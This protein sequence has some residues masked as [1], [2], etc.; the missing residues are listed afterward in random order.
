MRQIMRPKTK[1][2][3]R[4]RLSQFSTSEARA[5]LNLLADPNGERSGTCVEIGASIF[6]STLYRIGAACD[7]NADLLDAAMHFLERYGF[8]V[9]TGR[10]KWVVR[11]PLTAEDVEEACGLLPVAYAPMLPRET[12]FDMLRRVRPTKVA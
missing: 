10:L 2:D 6:G 4:K 12:A 7:L 9:E 8:V 1:F 11:K 5:A 3:E